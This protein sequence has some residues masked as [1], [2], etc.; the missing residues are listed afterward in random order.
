MIRQ[1][2]TTGAKAIRSKS[3]GKSTLAAAVMGVAMSV[4]GAS[5]AV[6]DL[7]FAIDE[8][9]SIDNNELQIMRDGFAAA[10]DLIPAVGEGGNTNTY[11]VTFVAF[12]SS[13]TTV[14]A[15]TVIDATTRATI[16]NTILNHTRIS[17][18]TSIAS[19]IDL[20]T[21]LTCGDGIT[22]ST[23]GAN[24]TLFNVATDGFGGDPTFSANPNA[25][26]AGVEGI[27]YEAIGSGANVTGLQGFA[28]PGAPVI[29]DLSNGDSIPNPL[30]TG[31]VVK[32]NSFSDFEDAIKAKVGKVVI[33][34]G[35]GGNVVPIPAAL[36]LLLTGFGAIGGIS[37]LR[38][39]KANKAA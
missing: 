28:F 25:V 13:A 4:S 23:C 3:I 32:V 15:P 17:G 10:M 5:A 39:R 7:G 18:G 11:R 12:A 6:I 16:K 19:A 34:T 31:F 8:S 29:V 2:F 14:V 33:D 36:P 21:K 35:G 22:V 37:A 27:S 1:I 20:L 9:G 30:T 24:T 26:A 38:R